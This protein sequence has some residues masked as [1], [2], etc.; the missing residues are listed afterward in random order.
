MNIARGAVKYPITMAMIF[1]AVV[2]L[3][4]ISVSRLG[5]DLL[6][7][8]NSPK[9]VIEVEAGENTPEDMERKF[10]KNVEAMVGT[11]NKVRRVSS[12]SRTGRAFITTEFSWDAD[13]DFALLDVQKKV[14][15]L[16]ED[17]EVDRISYSRFDP[18]AL[19]IMTLCLLGR[20]GDDMDG[21]R[22]EAEIVIKR[23]LEGLDGIASAKIAG[24]EKNEIIVR[25]DPHKLEAYELTESVII[26]KIQQTNIDA[27]GG[28]VEDN[29][30]VYIIKGV[31]RFKNLDDI[32]KLTV[33]Y[34]KPQLFE[35]ESS[36]AV[37][38]PNAPHTDSVPVEL[39]EVGEVY[40]STYDPE[41]IVVYNGE[42]GIGISVYKDAQANTVKISKIL[43]DE[44]RKLQNELTDTKLVITS[45]EARFINASINEVE[46]AAFYGMI[47]AV[48]VLFLF[49]RNIWSTLI[50]SLAIP[51]SIIATF[52]LMYFNNLTLNIMTLGGLAL[53]AG[54]LVDNAIIVVENIF[55]HQQAGKDRASAA[56][57]GTTEVGGALVA[58]TLTTII[59]FL[60]IVYVH[61]IGGE[62]FKEQGFTVAFSLL[63]SLF[64]AFLL[65]P[66]LA[67]RML[68]IKETKKQSNWMRDFYGRLV[69]GALRNKMAVIIIA[70]ILVV[71]SVYLIPVIG[72]EFIPRSDE[73]R[74]SLKVE[75]PEGT[76]IN[77]TKSVTD[78]IAEIINEVSD[79]NVEGIYSH[80]GRQP[81][82]SEMGSVSESGSHTALI[83]VKM[84]P[85]DTRKIDTQTFAGML[86][87]YLK[88]L[89]ETKITFRTQETSFQ[90][91]IGAK[92]GDI[93][94]EVSGPEI[95]ELKRLTGIVVERLK[96]VQELKDI[97]STFSEGR[98]EV[99]IQLDR[100]TAAGFGLDISTVSAKVR[101]LLEESDAGEMRY[102]GD[103]RSITV[104]YPKY[105]LNDLKNLLFKTDEGAVLHL[106]DVADLKI[107]EGP[108][109]IVRKNQVRVGEVFGTFNPNVKYSFALEK[110]KN[111]L[112]DIEMPKDYRLSIG[113]QEK[114]RAESFKNLKFALILAVILVY[115]VMSSLFES[116]VHP[117]TIMF[118]LPLAGIGTVITFYLWGEPFSLM[119]YIGIIMLA[120]I[121][122]NDAIVLVD[123]I[124]KKRMEGL[125]LNDAIIQAGKDRL[126]PILMTSLTTILALVPLT[127]GIGEGAKL[128]APMAVA[129]IGGLITSTIMTLIVIPVV[130]TYLDR[131]RGKRVLAKYN[132]KK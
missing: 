35:G 75:L 44:V 31:G 1:A 52:N 82:E 4:G 102:E 73:G 32:R 71:V 34:R 103:D 29:N 18:N 96:S 59:V 22:R 8:I 37:Q 9:V 19:P 70:V 80:I 123:Y 42:K 16:V 90:Q 86:G 51:L 24:G 57:D 81:S 40:F 27:S 125:G 38:N 45:E 68:K 132:E 36:G 115:M 28:R 120:G 129:V 5:V 99:N 33:G 131:I 111:S 88:D 76:R 7:D 107:L 10:T 15:S 118:S 112:K 119:A 17:D 62:L 69:S 92:E 78:R 94:I 23:R 87:H 72:N 124:H 54:M 98:P 116:I 41:N 127:L 95:D 114:E 43:Y 91:T 79:G 30:R 26:S 106:R 61:G 122:V 60:P 55:R 11:I 110:I 3:G 108:R 109:E 93:D 100:K 117:F 25:L 74:F 66:P 84:I 6:P 97:H 65:I 47:L 104:D 2:L 12:V 39:R 63:S 85:G 77:F 128:R 113:G 121:A 101:A 126:R 56:I 20:S 83:S 21:L 105:K 58:S 46:E 64:V 50:V 48:I 130:Y 53:G 49:L 13:M 67:A 89:P 14:G